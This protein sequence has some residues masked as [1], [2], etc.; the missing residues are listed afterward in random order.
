VTYNLDPW[1]ASR[2]ERE[3][4]KITAQ[5]LITRKDVTPKSTELLEEVIQ[6]R[7]CFKFQSPSSSSVA[8]TYASFE[9]NGFRREQRSEYSEARPVEETTFPPPSPTVAGR[10]RTWQDQTVPP[11][12]RNLAEPTYDF[13]SKGQKQIRGQCHEKLS[14]EHGCILGGPAQTCCATLECLGLLFE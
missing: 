10:R 6:S 4:F 12:I 2:F 8:Q 11:D 7:T 3:F 5:H 14:G 1:E 13:R 9:H